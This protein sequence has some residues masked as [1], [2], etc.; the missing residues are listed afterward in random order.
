MGTCDLFEELW[1]HGSQT[2]IQHFSMKL[3]NTLPRVMGTLT[4]VNSNVILSCRYNHSSFPWLGNVQLKV[5]LHVWQQLWRIWQGFPALVDCRHLQLTAHGLSNQIC[6]IGVPRSNNSP[7]GF[8]CLK[9]F[10]D[11]RYSITHAKLQRSRCNVMLSP[12]VSRQRRFTRHA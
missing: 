5:C 4:K 8:F 3:C 9:L 6:C 11:H 7:G 12:V 1:E 10:Y 2:E